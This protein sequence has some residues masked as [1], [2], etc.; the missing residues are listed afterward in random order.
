MT[1]DKLARVHWQ[2]GHALLPEHFEAQ[3]E[4]LSTE[5]RL[6]AGLSGLPLWGIARLKWKDA[7]LPGGLLDFS[8]LT[9]VMPD[10]VLVN[11]PGNAVLDEP[12]SLE[13]TGFTEVTIH[14]S[15][16]ERAPSAE[17]VQLYEDPPTLKRN[18]RVLHLSSGKVVEHAAS[19]LE[20]ATF[21]KDSTGKWMRIEEK[22]P[23]LLLVGPHPFLDGLLKDLD[24]VLTQAQGQL[25]TYIHDSSLRGDR[26]ASARRALCEVRAV[27]ALLLD[28]KHGVYPTPYRFFESLRRLYF[29]V[30]CYLETEP[31]EK[32][33]SYQHEDL[34]TGLHR[35]M[36]LLRGGI[37]PESVRQT[38]KPFHVRDGRFVLDELMPREDPPPNDF[39]LLVRR[40]EP[41]KPLSMHGVKLAS[42]KR[43][44][45][46]RRLALTGI[47]LPDAKPPAFPHNLDPE[48]DWY[49]LTAEGEE[50]EHAKGENSLCF[51]ATR[52][53]EGAE[54]LL[55][56]RRK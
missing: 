34:G 30:C 1:S 51:H 37:R 8:E 16:M 49:Q 43:L 3:E 54:V 27:Q 14:L 18:L 19:M 55:F 31:N 46:V 4:A 44:P 47:P 23:P 33:P 24:R 50:W 45:V 21:R 2:V 10:G 6:Y 38:H 20:L 56:W 35:W 39:Y 41:N 28:M 11:V 32:L 9:A 42:P 48:T 29:E 25:R 26:L 17:G 15:L 36:E 40:K 7:L 22:V 52:E 13:D 12:F 53:L 5:S